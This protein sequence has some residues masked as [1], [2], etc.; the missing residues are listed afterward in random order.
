MFSFSPFFS[1]PSL[2]DFWLCLFLFISPVSVTLP[3]YCIL[4][5][6]LT[7]SLFSRFLYLSNFLSLYLSPLNFFLSFFLSLSLSLVLTRSM[8]QILDYVVL[9]FSIDGDSKSSVE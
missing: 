6:S 1:H 8:K 4:S 3:F 5:F 9:K 2:L 7:T